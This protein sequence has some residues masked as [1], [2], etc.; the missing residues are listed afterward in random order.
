[1]AHMGHPLIGDDL[2]GKGNIME[3]M[4]LHSYF[5]GFLHP[6]GGE[7][8]EFVAQIPKHFKKALGSDVN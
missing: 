7:I 2:Y 5:V 1:M 6:I 3:S 4:M 8:L